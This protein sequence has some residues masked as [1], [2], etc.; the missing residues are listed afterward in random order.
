MLADEI[1]TTRTIK[2]AAAPSIVPDR[3]ID[4]DQL[5]RSAQDDDET[6]RDMLSLFGLQAELLL[7]RMTSEAPKIAAAHAHILAVSARLVGAWKVA[8]RATEFERSALCPGPVVL[9][10][11]MNC[12]SAA[13]ADAHVEV[14]T[15][16]RSNPLRALR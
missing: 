2:S 4:L 9:G 8:E 16:L 5:A 10:P 15:L 13:V 1:A 7:A 11:A 14:D 6:M 3:P 12:L